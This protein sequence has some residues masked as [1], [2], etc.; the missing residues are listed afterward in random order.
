MIEDE[1][2]AMKKSGSAFLLIP[3]HDFSMERV[4]ELLLD[5]KRMGS[6]GV[7]PS[8]NPNVQTRNPKQIQNPNGQNSKHLQHLNLEHLI[9]FRV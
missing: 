5:G 9:L 1:V 7:P 8:I 2:S 4:N 3:E 6:R